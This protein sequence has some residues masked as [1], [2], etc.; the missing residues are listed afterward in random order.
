MAHDIVRPALI[1]QAG[2]VPPYITPGDKFLG[3]KS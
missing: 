3:L 2:N 1:G